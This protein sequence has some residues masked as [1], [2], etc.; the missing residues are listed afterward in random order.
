MPT[1]FITVNSSASL[2]SGCGDVLDVYMMPHAQWPTKFRRERICQICL[3][4]ISKIFFPFRTRV[5]SIFP[6]HD[7][8][9]SCACLVLKVWVLIFS[10]S[11]WSLPREKMQ[12][13]WD[14]LASVRMLL[15]SWKAS[16]CLSDPPRAHLVF[17]PYFL[18]I[19]R[20]FIY[21][22]SNG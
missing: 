8:P 20:W 11:E 9:G 16:V 4:L 17:R 2:W 18:F 5:F 21:S 12:R 15:W 1:G 6:K 14:A 19:F 3:F 13:V 7:Q 22:L 10:Q